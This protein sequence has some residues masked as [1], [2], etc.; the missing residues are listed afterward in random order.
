MP[1]PPSDANAGERSRAVLFPLADKASPFGNGG[2]GFGRGIESDIK[3]STRGD[4][5]VSRSSSFLGVGG[6]RWSNGTGPRN[7]A[8]ARAR[9]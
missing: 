9:G 1:F 3:E 8:G 6:V 4:T 7:D 5:L 2:S